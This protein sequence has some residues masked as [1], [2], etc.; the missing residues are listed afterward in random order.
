MSK[1]TIIP[2]PALLTD[3]LILKDKNVVIVDVLRASST[4]LV[5]LANGA[6]EIVPA[7]SINT[8]AR[9]AKGLG[10]NTLLCGERAGK[11]VKGFNLGN[12]PLEYTREAIENKTLVFSTTNGTVSIHKARFAKKCL[13]VS[14]MNLSKVVEY[15]DN[16]N[17]D[18]TIICAGK[19]NNFC[20]E[21]FVLAGALLVKLFKLNKTK[22]LY[23]IADT[24]IAAKLLSKVMI[25]SASVLSKEK[26]IEMFKMSEHG[27]YLASIGF[28]EDI[29]VCSRIDEY[30][31]L[32]FV[33]KGVI[34]L[35]EN[36][37]AEQNT[38][39]NFKKI[40]LK[41]REENKKQH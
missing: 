35:Q 5:A 2:T 20:L 3:D 9:I 19:L 30:A 24:E 26:I 10:K 11:I 15:L 37:E 7:D 6:K 33:I 16:L 17:E 25:H 22:P 27:T 21:D 18:F 31:I 34:K 8:A 14:F 13:L 28:E 29:E 38:K 12:S 36:I 1:I 40:N 4:M 32:P 39:K 23:E 41:E